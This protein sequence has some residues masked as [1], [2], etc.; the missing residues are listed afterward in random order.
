MVDSV[1]EQLTALRDEDWAIR[2]E[3]ARLLGRFKDPRAVTPLVSLLR[4][5]DRSVREAAVDALRAIGAPAVEALGACLIDSE[6]AVQEAASAI[7]ATI[8]DER[9]LTPLLSA[10]KSSD[11]IVRM[12]AAQA[13]GRVKSTRPWK[14]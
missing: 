3:A 6:L 10:L 9:V 5:E 13:L 14:P 11:W 7:L 2:E 8:A 1:R 4:D 12:H